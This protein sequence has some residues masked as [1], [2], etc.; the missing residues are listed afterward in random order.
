[1][2]PTSSSRSGGRGGYPGA[3]MVPITLAGA[4][5]AVSRKIAARV[6]PV[7]SSR[8]R[9]ARAPTTRSG[10]QR[11]RMVSRWW[12]STS[13]IIR[14]GSRCMKGWRTKAGRR[15]LP[16]GRKPEEIVAS[17]AR[18]ISPRRPLGDPALELPVPGAEPPVLVDHEA[19]PCADAGHQRLGLRQGRRERLLAQDVDAAVGRRLDPRG[20]GL[21]RR[22]DVEGVEMLARDHRLGVL[23]DARDAELLR[24]RRARAAGSGSLTATT[25]ARGPAFRHAVRWYQLIMPAPARP[26]RSG[27]DR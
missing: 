10:P 4:P 9:L 3:A 24:A 25:S 26:T 23:V 19:H 6:S 27:V 1:M 2:L 11:N 20:M 8:V 22:R 15:P 13:A 17:R 5:A 14:R 16:S 7:T 12:I 21:A 18:A